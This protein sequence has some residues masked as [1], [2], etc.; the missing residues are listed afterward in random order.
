M[1]VGIVLLAAGNS[2]RLGRSKQL[3]EINDI[4]LLRRSA[5]TAIQTNCP[6]VVV[7]G[8]NAAAHQNVI[9]DLESVV[10]INSNWQLGMGHS[11][12]FGLTTLL[13]TYTDLQ[14]VMILVCD[15]PF[16][17][18][19]HLQN[20]LHSLH[21][22]NYS[23]VASAYANV[24]GVPALFRKEFFPHLLHMADDAGARKVIQQF[25]NQVYTVPFENGEIDLDTPQDL[26]HLPKI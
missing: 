1:Q 8:A 26:L 11:L 21:E 3:V 4:P 24:A 17:S 13:K 25:P 20:L 6:V 5:E 18:V 22:Q 9:A 23:I 19:T 15:Q 7:L 14:A 10:V 2:S 12:K 16:L